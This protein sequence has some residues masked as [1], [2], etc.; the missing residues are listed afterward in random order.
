MFFSDAVFAIAMTLLV[1]DLKLPA[2]PS[3][4][5]AAQF[6]GIL[7]DQREPLAGFILSFVLVGRLWLA[8]HRRFNAMKGH[9]GKLQVINLLALF[10]V[11]FLPVPTA[12]LFEANSQTP[13]PPVI[14]SLTIS[15][16]FLSLNWLWRHAYRSG[17]MQ[18]WVDRPMYRLVLR[19]QDPGWVVFVMS[20]PVEFIRPDF[21]LF[22]WI[23]ILPYSVISGKYQMR[24]FVKEQTARLAAA[25]GR[26]V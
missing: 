24:R 20:I 18:P 5:T 10:F 14:Y 23:L 7:M 1:L 25:T 8:H 15:G 6:N 4:M 19:S 17:L 3:N 13:W 11:V 16:S 2:M 21:A 26:E 12:L 9:D 22:S